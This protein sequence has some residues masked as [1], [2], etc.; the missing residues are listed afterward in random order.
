MSLQLDNTCK[1]LPKALNL[2]KVFNNYWIVLLLLPISTTVCFFNIQENM[3]TH[4]YIFRD[5][6]TDRYPSLPIFVLYPNGYK[7]YTLIYILL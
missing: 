1:R 2:G 6:D 4:T 3:T 7:L 5:I